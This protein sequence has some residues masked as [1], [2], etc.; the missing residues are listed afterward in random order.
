MQVRRLISLSITKLFKVLVVFYWFTE[1]L[2]IFSPPW[3][4]LLL[5]KSLTKRPQIAVSDIFQEN[6]KKK[7]DSENAK[8]QTGHGV[9]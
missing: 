4:L 1:T 3:A 9:F 7:E 8:R 6:K 5:S 2:A